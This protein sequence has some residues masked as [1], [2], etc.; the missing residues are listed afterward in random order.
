MLVRDD[1]PLVGEP[2]A[3]L[4]AR[5]RP[6]ARR[7][8]EHWIVTHEPRA[9]SARYVARPRHGQGRTIRA[10]TVRLLNRVLSM[11][12]RNRTDVPG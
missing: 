3:E 7:F 6:V 4:P 2:I 10:D 12:E 1:V 9:S 5:L 8:A 11:A